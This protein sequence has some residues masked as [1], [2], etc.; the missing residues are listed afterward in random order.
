M[1]YYAKTTEGSSVK[2][3]PIAVIAVAGFAVAAFAGVLEPSGARG[4]TPDAASG[5]VT[6]L[7]TGSADV[8]PNRAS[9]AFGTVSQART[10]AAAMGA[11]AEAAT[12]VVNALRRAGVDHDDIQT[13]EVS[14]APRTNDNGDEIVGYTATNTVTANVDRI[15]DAGG[16]VDAAVAAGANQV[17]GPNLLA[18]DQDATYRNALKAAVAEARAKAETLAAA[19]GKSLGQVTA[20]TE[21]G[22]ISPLPMPTT[23]AAK[24]S[25]VQIE[26]GT[27]TIEASV[28]VTFAFA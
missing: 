16:V 14:L 28:S 2:L 9:F 15:A 13:S 11:S 23:G 3:I 6:A 27:Q 26:P 5:T 22:A 12:R 18:S 17:Y 4:Q 10:A 24:D 8:T 25:A 19:A 20:V 1:T 21:G 7:G